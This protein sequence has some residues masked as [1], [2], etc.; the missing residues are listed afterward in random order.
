MLDAYDRA[1]MSIYANRIRRAGNSCWSQG[2][3]SHKMPTRCLLEGFVV[4]KS[5]VIKLIHT[6]ISSSLKQ[7]A[8]TMR[9]VR[10]RP[11]IVKREPLGELPTSVVLWCLGFV[12]LM[13]FSIIRCVRQCQI[14]PK[15]TY[16]VAM[17]GCG[18]HDD[19]QRRS[20]LYIYMLFVFRM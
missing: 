3:P 6:K 2:K 4:L 12:C 9:P 13:E 10:V 14:E 19:E 5:V 17:C 18:K 7:I 8:I 20:M 16:R 1:R 15:N 11:L